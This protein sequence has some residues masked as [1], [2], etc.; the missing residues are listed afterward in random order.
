MEGNMKRFEQYSRRKCIEI[1][2]IPSSITND[3][4]EEQVLRSLMSYWRQWM[5]WPVIDLEKQTE[6]L[7]NF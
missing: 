2:G 3:L 4:L 7:L 6:L 1:A 5:L